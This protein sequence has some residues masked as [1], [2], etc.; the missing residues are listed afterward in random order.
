VSQRSYFRKQDTDRLGSKAMTQCTNTG[1]LSI[2]I[3]S[4][5]V[6]DFHNS[7]IL[8]GIWKWS[9]ETKQMFLKG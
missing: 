4:V 5:Y 2:Y 7:M 1:S 3:T 8:E 6:Y 9:R